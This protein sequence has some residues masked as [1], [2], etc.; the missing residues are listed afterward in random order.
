MTVQEIYEAMDRLAPFSTSMSFDNTGLLLGE[1]NT[2]VKALLL[3]LDCSDAA[4]AE[5]ARLGANLILSHHPLIFHALKR[6]PGD[7]T[8]CRALRQGVAVISAHTNLDLA[9]GGVNDCLAQR[10]GLREVRGLQ[11]EGPGLYLG[12][13]GKLPRPM[14][15]PELAAYVKERLGGPAIRNR[16]GGK[17]I[18]TLALCGGSGDDLLPAAIGAGAQALL[19]GEVAHDVF[20]EAAH[21]GFSLLE[22]GHAATEL[23]LLEPL[24]QRLRG[25]FPE[26]PIYVF[27]EDFVSYC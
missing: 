25:L 9:Q 26:L 7:S 1:P 3:A 4:L 8:V 5:A 19:T 12:R 27:E 14:R 16:D 20:V 15:A 18:E 24:A 23:V 2:P 21:R 11:E 13:V 6:L 22:A 10:L 17:A